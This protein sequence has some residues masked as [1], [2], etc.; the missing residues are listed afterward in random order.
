MFTSRRT[1]AILAASSVLALLAGGAQAA[2]IDSWNTDNVVVGPED[3]IDTDDVGG[4][5]V[6]YDRDVTGGVG[7]AE[8]NGQ[9]TYIAPESNTPGVKVEGGDPDAPD[10]DPDFYVGAKKQVFDGCIMASSE[11]YC[12]SGFQSGKRIK[13]QVTDTGTIDLVFDISPEGDGQEDLTSLYQVYHRLINVTGEALAGFTVELGTGIGDAFTASTDGDGLGFSQTVEFGPDDLAAFSQYPF[14]LFGGDPLNPNPL[15][16]PGFFD[17]GDPDDPNNNGRA[18]FEVTLTE[19]K[20]ASGDFYGIYDDL[21]GGW[22]SQEDVPNGIF[23]DYDPGN[24]DPLLLGWDTGDGWEFLRGYD[25]DT[26]LNDVGIV[27]I[28]S[29][30]V[31]EGGLFEYLTTNFPKLAGFDF[32]FID[33]ILAGDLIGGAIEDLANL[34]LTFALN[35]SDRF[36]MY[37][38][39]FTMRVTTVA[40]IPLPAGA[41]LLLGGLGALAMVRRRR[42]R[43][44]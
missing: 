28:A 26:D 35:V 37:N 31:S 9:I 43:A 30:M 6:I 18:G 42:R 17:V 7:D 12:D 33:G 4:A 8:T 20:I 3:T 11:A 36:A 39:T 44:A 19:D 5:S 41:P 10:Y 15:N 25:A 21:F 13:Q 14:G 34:N 16:L 23:Y 27:P 2:T 32:T 40:P 1:Q 24:A 29:T 38:D 22:L